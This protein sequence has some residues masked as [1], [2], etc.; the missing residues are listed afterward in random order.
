MSALQEKAL[1][2]SR[3]AEAGGASPLGRARMAISL[4]AQH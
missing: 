2:R 1:E 4:I 3:A